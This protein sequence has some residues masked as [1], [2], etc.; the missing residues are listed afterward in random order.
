MNEK[1]KLEDVLENLNGMEVTD[2]IEN[3]IICAFEDYE[4]EGVSEI[5]VNKHAG[6]KCD[7][8]AYANYKY[9]PIILIK[10]IDGIIKAYTEYDLKYYE[11][12]N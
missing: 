9:S 10:I 4:Y 7:Y 6:K 2:D 5:I 8:Q 11:N 1:M 3:D 12:E